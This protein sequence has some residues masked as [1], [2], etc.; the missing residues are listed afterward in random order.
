MGNNLAPNVG[1]VLIYKSLRRISEQELRNNEQAD[2][3]LAV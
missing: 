2:L 1:G 3:F